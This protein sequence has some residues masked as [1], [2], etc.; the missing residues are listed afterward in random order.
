MSGVE[1]MEWVRISRETVYEGRVVDVLR[2]T[3]RIT[4]DGE[5]RQTKYDVVH[6]PG[7]AAIVALF[8]DGSV[9]LI[10]QFRYAVGGTIWEIPAGTLDD[11]E[12]YE[13]CAERELAE[14]T[15][16]RAG[17]W[18]PLVAFYTTPGFCDEELRVFLAENLTEGDGHAEADEDLEV[19]RVPLVEAL[20]WA[21]TGKIR[22]AKTIAG[23][24]AAR[25]H[26]EGAGRWPMT[27]EGRHR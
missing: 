22:D 2:D 21:A 3:V 5:E 15:G 9:A 23:L 20:A 8:D 4:A 12:T 13:A 7:A 11:A 6:H 25:V 18:T 24:H 17:S 26:L 19:E 14:E 16:Y 1:F 10:R 27:G